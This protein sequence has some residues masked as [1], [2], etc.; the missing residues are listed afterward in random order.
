[1][2]IHVYMQIHKHV[3]HSISLARPFRALSPGASQASPRYTI[4]C[5]GGW[6][7]PMLLPPPLVFPLAA[8]W[9]LGP[10]PVI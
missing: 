3:H 1:M 6:V 8:V 4:R 5:V 7:S 10:P 9:G 2:Y